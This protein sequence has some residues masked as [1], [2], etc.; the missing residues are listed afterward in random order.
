MDIKILLHLEL[1]SVV[2]P[3]NLRVRSR[4]T[5]W[6]FMQF[7]RF[8]QILCRIGHRLAC[9]CRSRATSQKGAVLLMIYGSPWRHVWKKSSRMK[10]TKSSNASAPNRFYRYRQ[11]SGNCGPNLVM[12]ATLAGMHRSISKIGRRLGTILSKRSALSYIFPIFIGS[13]GISKYKN[14]FYLWNI[15]IISPVRDWA[16]ASQSVTNFLN[17]MLRFH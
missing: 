10:R 7:C 8:L 6:F 3:T 12:I 13:E 2:D 11:I 5:C 4:S 15:W 1:Y 16:R 14:E 9:Q 17:W